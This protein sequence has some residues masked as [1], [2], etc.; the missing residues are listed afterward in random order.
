MVKVPAR[1]QAIGAGGRGTEASSPIRSSKSRP[2][3]KFCVSGANGECPAAIRS[4]LRNWRQLTEPGSNWA[5][6]VV[7]PAPF[8]SA[9][10]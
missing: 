10:N 6:N 9:I 5:A 4:A 3:F 2:A 1:S 8:G 7:F